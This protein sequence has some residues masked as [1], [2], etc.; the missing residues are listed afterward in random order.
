M[1]KA[2]SLILALMMLLTLC[3]C[4]AEGGTS[5]QGTANK[6][7]Y[8]FGESI[9]S[10]SGMFVFTPEFDGFAAA[11]ANYPDENYLRPEG[12]GVDES[13]NPYV[14]EDGKV[15][16]YCSAKVEYVGGSKEDE[17]F[18]FS[19]K[20]DYDGSYTFDADGIRYSRD[21]E[22]W[23][24]GYDSTSFEPLSTDTVRYVRF[25]FEV[26]EVVSQ[27]YEKRTVTVITIEDQ[28][29]TFP[30]DVKAAAD[31]WAAR[32]AAAEAKHAE[33][34]AEV[35]A[36]LSKEI[37]GKLQGSWGWSAYGTAGSQVYTI[38]HDLTF[39]GDAVTIRTETTLMNTTMQNTGTYYIAKAYI[40]M[41]F[42][43]GSQACMPYT[44]ENGEI[45]LSQEVEGA[46]YTA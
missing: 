23:D 10:P 44:Y 42:Q 1:K 8:Q 2:V 33:D 19:A 17:T 9:T 45:S 4:G 39:S 32:E 40:V 43:D 26:P 28:D 3:A 35:D 37:K 24:A 30:V 22:D 34:M 7:E 13:N 38:T 46:F 16:M 18:R 36:E 27:D 29:Y 6:D 21:E 31:A 15:M 20:L 12:R 11:V 41:N 14:A 25:C 5:A